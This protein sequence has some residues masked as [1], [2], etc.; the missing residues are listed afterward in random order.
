MNAKAERM[1][2]RNPQL[3]ALCLAIAMALA[4]PL[5]ALPLTAQAQDDTS[6]QQKT[7]GLQTDAEEA[8]VDAADVDGLIEADV[9]EADVLARDDASAQQETTAPQTNPEESEAGDDPFALDDTTEQQSEPGKLEELTQV[10]STVEAGV[11]HVSD[12]SFR[13]GRYTGL[14]DE[15]VAPLLNLDLIRRAAYDSDSAQYWRLQGRD[16]GLDSRDATLEFGNQGRFGVRLDYNQIPYFRSDSARTIFNGAGSN[17]L[18]LPGNWVGDGNTVTMTEL[19]PSLRPVDLHTERRQAGLGITGVLSPRW[20]FSTSYRH[21]TKEGI[22]SI[23]GVFGNSGG[24][25]RAVILPEPVDYTTQQIDVALRYTTRK[26]Q[27]EAAYYL[28]VFS[29]HEDALVWS[30]P[31]TTINGWGPGAGFPDGRGQISLPPDNRFH[32]FSVNGGYNFSDQTRFSASVATGRMTQDQTFLPYTSIPELAASITQPLPRASL[33]GRIDTTVVNLRIASRP[34]PDFS[35][36]VSYRYDDRDNKTPR[37]EYV[38][39]GGDTQLQQT[40]PTSDRRRYNEPYSFRE[41]Q[42]KADAAYRAF[43]NVNLSAGVQHKKTDRTYTEREHSDETTYHFGINT[44]LGERLNGQLRYTHADR[45]G[46]TYVGNEPFLSG[47]DPGYTATVAGGFENL[48]GLRKYYLANRDRD[49]ISAT[50][51]FMPTESWTMSASVDQA[52]DEYNQSE[53]GL[54]DSRIDSFT[55][56]TVYAPSQLW[57]AFLF[58]NREE[59]DSNQNGRAFRGGGSKLAQAGDPDQNWSV[60][61]RDNIDSYGAG[62]KRSLAGTRLDF[63]IEYLYSKA[64]SNLDFAAG[65]ALEVAPLPRDVT[66]LNSLNVHGTFKMRPNTALR[67][68]YWYERYHSTDWSIDGIEPNQL[69]NVILLGETSPDYK[70]HVVSLSLIYRF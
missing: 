32:Q 40:D 53:F 28:S 52:K 42:Y 18:T 12:D 15:G 20:D 50:A 63:G 38:Y 2:L 25:P 51:S 27:V 34:W 1:Q 48:P 26:L 45:D 33:D 21:E 16:L 36:N 14:N 60:R 39:I 8:D 64:H 44:Q 70:V 59:L 65:S 7:T 10:R 49:Q 5:A 4:L 62:Y 41:E 6:G 22:K 23:G 11:Y 17:N 66:R 47:Y 54:L 58:Y 55:F 31:Y 29:E 13:F 46:S 9:E 3:R 68:G 37:D 61:H 43:G 19:L 69:A 57:S 24:N 67:L 35:W 30:N 56:E